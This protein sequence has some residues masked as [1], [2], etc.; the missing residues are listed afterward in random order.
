MD[1]IEPENLVFKG[2]R[3]RTHRKRRRLWA[4]RQF[5]IALFAILVAIVF[6]IFLINTLGTHRGD[7]E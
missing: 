1:S 2:E 7:L 6:V 5:W 3:R 4:R